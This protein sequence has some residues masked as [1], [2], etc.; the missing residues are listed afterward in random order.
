MTGCNCSKTPNKS[1][2]MDTYTKL[3]NINSK[4]VL[5][6]EFTRVD[7]VKFKASMSATGSGPD[8]E[9]AKKYS[10]RNIFILLTEFLSSNDPKIVDYIYDIKTKCYI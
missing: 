4:S 9:T 6:G 2:N 5:E 3:V 10:Q 1:V 7:G 8:C